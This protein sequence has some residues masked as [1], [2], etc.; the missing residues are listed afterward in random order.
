MDAVGKEMKLAIRQLCNLQFGHHVLKKWDELDADRKNYVIEEIKRRFIPVEGHPVVPNQWIKSMMVS[1]MSHKRSEARDAFKEGKPKPSWLDAEEWREIQQETEDN[2]TKFQ[3]QR[4]AA[5]AKNESVGS[6][7]LGSGGY[8][9]LR[10][11]FVST[12]TH[13]RSLFLWV[14]FQ[15]FTCT[16]LIF[17]MGRWRSQA[18]RFNRWRS[19]M[20]TSMVRKRYLSS[21]RERG[22]PYFGRTSIKYHLLYNFFCL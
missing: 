16:N 8:D 18:G 12:Y 15:S 14:Q 21:L 10:E 13:I 9:T 1:C 6:S 22:L 2:P 3:Q 11:E 7:H 5:R 19:V 4:D 17:G 20:R